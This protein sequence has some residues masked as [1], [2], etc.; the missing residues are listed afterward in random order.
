MNTAISD[1]HD[2]SKLDASVISNYTDTTGMNTAIQ[3]WHDPQKLDVSTASSTYKTI[4]SYSSDIANYSTTSQMNTAISAYH[5]P[6]KLDVSTAASTY[7][8]IATNNTQDSRLTALEATLASAG[9][10]KTWTVATSGGTHT[11]IAAAYAAASDGDT[12]E[13]YPGT[14]SFPP[15]G[16]SKQ[17]AFVGISRKR[18]IITSTATSPFIYIIDVPNV[19]FQNLT[20]N[21]TRL[22]SHTNGVIFYPHFATSAPPSF[23]LID[24]DITFSVTDTITD[25]SNVGIVATFY[26]WTGQ[27]NDNI[28]NCNLTVSGSGNASAVYCILGYGARNCNLKS[29]GGSFPFGVYAYSTQWVNNCMINGDLGGATSNLR[30]DRA[31]VYTG[32]FTASPVYTPSG[33]EQYHDSS[34]LDTSVAASTYS[35]IAVNNTQDSRLTALESGKLDTSVAASTYKTITSFDLQYGYVTNYPGIRFVAASGGSASPALGQAYDSIASAISGASLIIV[36]PGTYIVNNVS[37]PANVTI[38]GYSKK[39]TILQNTDANVFTIAGANV[40]LLNL[41]ITSTVSAQNTSVDTVA[42]TSG[43]GTLEIRECD[44]N[45]SVSTTTG[46]TGV[47]T[48]IMNSGTDIHTINNTVA[49]I[50]CRIANVNTGFG[51]NKGT[52][53]TTGDLHFDSCQISSTTSGIAA[54]TAGG[55][56]QFTNCIINGSTADISQ[57]SGTIE[58]NKA[59]ILMNNNANSLPFTSTFNEIITATAVS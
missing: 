28:Q 10:G 45:M 55:D 40:S 4:S 8:T 36:Y 16:I 37:I 15:Q 53:V 54:E 50:N 30:M 9:K 12:I 5:D 46:D 2:A 1:Y 38:R 22:A 3:A 44:I 7:S 59:T 23:Y 56:S 42:I 57:T 29:S 47:H 32:S 43:N 58:I 11:T 41:T 21:A 18:S 17:L 48:A 34:K 24:C 51:T 49:I 26:G 14:W 39:R 20:I 35:T 13:I 25:V 33:V 6:Q 52:Y 27:I 31:T 19:S